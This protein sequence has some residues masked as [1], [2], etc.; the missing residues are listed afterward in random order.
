[1]TPPLAPGD[2]HL[3][4]ARLDQQADSLAEFATTLSP[5]ERERAKRL[6]HTVD[7]DRFVLRR[8]ILRAILSL[9]LDVAPSKHFMQSRARAESGWILNT[10]SFSPTWKASP[11]PTSRSENW[12]FCA[13]FL[14]VSACSPS[15]PAGHERKPSSR[16]SE[17]DCHAPPNQVEVYLDS[18][19]TTEVRVIEGPGAKGRFWR[20][21]TVVPVPGYVGA[22]AA[23]GG[24]WRI[25]WLDWQAPAP[26]HAG[27]PSSE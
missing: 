16:R 6:L 22:V 4:C 19:N 3:W 5:G 26:G 8:G 15:S 13:W 14:R 25:K 10:W 9:Y 11:P 23:E 27:H 18:P 24:D 2:V 1:M 7:R 20:V 12:M 21:D 17:K